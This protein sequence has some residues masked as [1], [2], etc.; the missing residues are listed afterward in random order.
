MAVVLQQLQVL[1][2]EDVQHVLEAGS[3]SRLGYLLY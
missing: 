2:M 1:M 3:V